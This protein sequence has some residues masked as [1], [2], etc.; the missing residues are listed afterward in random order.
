MVRKERRG[1]RRKRRGGKDVYVD[2]EMIDN[3]VIVLFRNGE[4]VLYIYGYTPY[5]YIL[6]KYITG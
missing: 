2:I 1:E 3:I 4:D 5:I 6:L